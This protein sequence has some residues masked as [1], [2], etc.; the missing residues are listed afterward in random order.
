MFREANPL[1]KKLENGECVT[2]SVLYSWSP[3]VMDA[4]GNAGLDFMRIDMEHSWRQDEGLEHVIR[5]GMIAGVT[6]IVRV[7]RDNPYL[8]R[9]ALEIGA[10]GI[11]VPD[12]STP[13]EARKV[14]AASKFPPHGNRGYSGN[15][16]SGYWGHQAGKEWIEWSNREPMIGAMIENVEAMEHIDEIVATPGLDFFHFGPSDYS[17][18]MGLGGPDWNHPEI[19][20]ALAKTIKAARSVNKHVLLSVGLSEEKI[21]KYGNLGLTMFELMNDLNL[22][23]KTWSVTNRFAREFKPAPAEVI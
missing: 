15:C 1:R 17:M 2:G 4:A 11:I 7:D 9:K 22:L 10:G 12:V 5:A 6:S 20:E 23:N 18:S 16:W 13:E 14:A 3:N 8:I 21:E 19:Q